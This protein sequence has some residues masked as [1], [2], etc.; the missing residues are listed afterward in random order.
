MCLV[1]RAFNRGGQHFAMQR[2]ACQISNRRRSRFLAGVVVRDLCAVRA[3]G[4]PPLLYEELSD[5]LLAVNNKLAVR[6][7][8]PTSELD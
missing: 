4:S 6:G 5:Q 2:T 3:A 8:R 7:R 1:Q